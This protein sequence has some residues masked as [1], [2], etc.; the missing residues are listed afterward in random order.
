MIDIDIYINNELN[1]DDKV[2]IY[3]IM[4]TKNDI[5]LNNVEREENILIDNHS[6][7]LIEGYIL[8][9]TVEGMFKRH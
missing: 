5:E 6:K 7:L 9:T 1:I 4:E 8:M 2:K 3:F